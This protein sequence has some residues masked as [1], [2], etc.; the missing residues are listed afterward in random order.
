MDY[1]EALK[2][3][4]DLCK[5]GIN[6]GL[7]RIKKLLALLEN[8]QQKIKTIHVAGTN[9]KGSTIAI[10]TS[11]LME[12]GYKVGV[13]TSP[14]LHS[15]RE[16]IRINNQDIPSEKFAL[17]MEQI[18]ELLPQV[19]DNIGE[20]PTEFE[21]LTA[22]AFQYF[23]QEKVDIA[24]MEV[25]MGGRLD[26]TNV[27]VPE[28][29]VITAIGEDHINF[30]GPTIG[31]IAKE[32]AGIIKED[33]PVVI[34]IQEKQVQQVLEEEARKLRAPIVKAGEAVY[35]QLYF[36]SE[37]QSFSLKTANNLYPKLTLNLLGD[38]QLDNATTA[39]S[40]IETLSNLGW[41]IPRAAI[42]KGLARA[43]WPGRL[44]FIKSTPPILFDGAHNP[45]GALALARAIPK[46]FNYKRIIM[47]IAILDDKDKGE[48]LGSL[49]P[50]ADIIV[51]T[52]VPDNPRNTE[53]KNINQL[54]H[55]KKIF[56]E[57]DT[58]R[59]IDLAMEISNKD[60]LVVIT[61]SLYLL[62]ASRQYVLKHY[63]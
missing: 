2:F 37:G 42:L 60:D 5:F 46:Y 34:A 54:I 35:E 8:P 38:H 50:L 9:G 53:W 62:G 40:C 17:L 15:Y 19:L 30:L 56:L 7:D 23:S 49:A 18:K 12:A 28:L 20:T 48:I 61:G 3:L 36:N 22:L 51:A 58:T 55:D 32:K 25:G 63:I 27:I 21:V 14:H 44:E 16:R 39:I 1:N 43:Q 26:S 11:I 29:A 45:Q 6:L 57:E 47:V 41:Q 59:A 33:V 10:L 24:I 4:Q 13:Y 52:K 31:D